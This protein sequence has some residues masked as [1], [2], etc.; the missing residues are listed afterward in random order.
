M[1]LDEKRYSP[2]ISIPTFCRK[3]KSTPAKARR[4]IADG[5]LKSIVEDGRPRIYVASAIEW[6]TGAPPMPPGCTYVQDEAA[7]DDGKV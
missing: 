7:T 4:L 1:L 2:Y 3:Y 6:A 5:V